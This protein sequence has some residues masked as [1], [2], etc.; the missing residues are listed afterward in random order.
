MFD[1]PCVQRRARL[2]CRHGRR[3]P[4]LHRIVWGKSSFL[5]WLTCVWRTTA[6]LCRAREN[7]SELYADSAVDTMR[8]YGLKMLNLHKKA[9]AG[10]GFRRPFDKRRCKLRFAAFVRPLRCR[11]VVFIGCRIQA[12]GLRAASVLCAHGVVRQAL[13]APPTAA[14]SAQARAFSPKARCGRLRCG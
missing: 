2:R 8:A 14:V 10:K 9:A 12:P 5:Y 4:R 7:S 11:T 13:P 6:F 3:R 1:S